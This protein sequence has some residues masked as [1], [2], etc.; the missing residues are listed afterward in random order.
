MKRAV[1][2]TIDTE[3]LDRV[4]A[5]RGMVKRSTIIDD[6][7]KRGLECRELSVVNKNGGNENG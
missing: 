1:N 5:M 4:E 2:L 6:L 7:L 3:T